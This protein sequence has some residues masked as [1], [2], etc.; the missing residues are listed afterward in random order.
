M[1]LVVPVDPSFSVG[2]RSSDRNQSGLL[3]VDRQPPPLLQQRRDFLTIPREG[4]IESSPT[5]PSVSVI[6]VAAAFAHPGVETELLLSEDSAHR[7]PDVQVPVHLSDR[8]RRPRVLTLLGR[9]TFREDL[10]RK[11]VEVLV[12][13]RQPKDLA[14]RCNSLS[15]L[16]CRTQGQGR[17][18][19]QQAVPARGSRNPFHARRLEGPDRLLPVPATDPALIVQN[20]GRAASVCRLSRSN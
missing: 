5:Y 6:Q 3:R 17:R 18:S 4:Q 9:L 1:A 14:F 15:P 16:P 11:K 13:G 7:I 12:F 8:V 2:V 20:E 19:V 10:L